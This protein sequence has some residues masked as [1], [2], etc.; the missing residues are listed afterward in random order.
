MP[1]QPDSHLKD[2]ESES[3]Y[4]IR[5]V[6]A[7]FKKPVVPLY[8]AKKRKVVSQGNLWIPVE[9]QEIAFRREVPPEEIQEVSCRYRSLGCI[10]CTGAV[11]SEAATL[12][13]VIEEIFSAKRS[14]RENR[15]IDQTGDASM[16]QKKK[17]GYF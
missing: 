2:L 16:E 7:N 3:I 13:E 14:E 8:F 15:L 9:H 6:A 1:A 17:E 5:E 10:P 12:D 4:I 11:A